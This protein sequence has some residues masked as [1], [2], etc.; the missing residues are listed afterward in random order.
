MPARG[1]RAEPLS[2][3]AG[4]YSLLVDVRNR[5]VAVVGKPTP[6]GATLRIDRNPALACRGESYCIFPT[7][8]TETIM[9][10]LKTGSLAL[11]DVLAGKNV[12]GQHQHKGVSSG[13]G[14]NSCRVSE[15]Y[16][17]SLL[18]M[19]LLDLSVCADKPNE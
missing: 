3:P 7:S 10:Q 5:L 17:I 8:D 4:S 13:P 1:D 14:Q 16:L 19:R 9:R 12:S 2:G 18:L 11:V 6:S 15:T